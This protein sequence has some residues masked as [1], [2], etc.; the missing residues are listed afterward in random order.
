MSLGIRWLG[1]STVVIDLD[2]ARVVADP[3]LLRHNGILRRRGVQPAQSAWAGADAVLLSHL[4]YDHAELGSL[5]LLG[6]VPIYTAAANAQWARRKDLDGRAIGTDAWTPIGKGDVEI[7]LTRAIHESRPMPHRPNAANGHLVRG[8]SGRVWVA[9]DT[10]LF[11]DMARL[12]DAA[13]GP[14]DL[15]VVPVGGWGKRLSGGHMG[16]VEAAIACR[17]V[18]ARWAVPVHWNTLHLPAVRTWPHDWMD[19]AGPEF[20]AALARE[21]PDCRAAV[22]G[23]GEMIAV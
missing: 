4:H 21:A 6:N 19:A 11:D 23:L 5:R 18:G 1:H 7:R 17:M 10:E 22:L 3:L 12:P 9:G 8:P 16:P 15:A 20:V 2:G 13:G 14:I